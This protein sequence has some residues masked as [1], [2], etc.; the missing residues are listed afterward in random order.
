MPRDTWTNRQ[1]T[2]QGRELS[3]VIVEVT[4]WADVD[5]TSEQRDLV[6]ELRGFTDKMN[7]AATALPEEEAAEAVQREWHD[8]RSRAVRAL[9][10][11]VTRA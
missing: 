11:E 10:R 2:D 8:L 9:Q 4:Q 3:Q 7:E 1:I 6:D 5:E